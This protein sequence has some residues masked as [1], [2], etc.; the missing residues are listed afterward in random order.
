MSGTRK[1]RVVVVGAGIAGSLIATGL[2]DHP[3]SISFAWNAW[4]RTTMPRRAPAS[5]SDQTR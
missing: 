3:K 2:M 4:D 5:T 1:K